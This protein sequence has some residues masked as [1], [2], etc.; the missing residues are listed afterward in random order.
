MDI[1]KNSSILR[2]RGFTFRNKFYECI[3]ADK[4]SI[5]GKNDDGG[6]IVITRTIAFITLAQ[7][8]PKMNPAVCIEAVERL[9]DYFRDKGK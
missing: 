5:Y 7:Y 3:R 8:A 6:G 2:E 4:N 1:F 9:S